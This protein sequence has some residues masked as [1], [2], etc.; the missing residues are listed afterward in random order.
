MFVRGIK[1]V[2]RLIEEVR[3]SKLSD[4]VL[5]RW[6]GRAQVLVTEVRLRELAG[7]ENHIKTSSF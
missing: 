6:S 4:I 7:S 2:M 5:V 1:L 3:H